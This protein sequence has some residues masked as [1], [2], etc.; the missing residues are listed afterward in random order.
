MI[1]G[2]VFILYP[3]AMGIIHGV[4]YLWQKGQMNVR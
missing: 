4:K 3:S 1:V 2:I